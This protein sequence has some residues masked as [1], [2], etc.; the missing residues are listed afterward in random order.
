MEKRKTQLCLKDKEAE[1]LNEYISKTKL[2][3]NEL[4]LK[5][6]LYCWEEMIDVSDIKL[7]SAEDYKED[8]PN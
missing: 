3:K 4:I 8:S 7:S 2:S 5:C 1:I 6:M